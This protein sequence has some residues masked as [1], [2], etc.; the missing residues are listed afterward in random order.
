MEAKL[1]DVVT[2]RQFESEEDLKTVVSMIEK[3]LSEPYPIYT[4]RYFVHKWPHL[5][6]LAFL[7]ADPTKCI[8]CIISKLENHTKPYDQET[9]NRGY[10]AM[11]AVDPEHRRLGLGRRLVER[12]ID[13]MIGLEADEIYLETEVTNTAALRLYECK[14]TVADWCSD[15][16]LEGQAQHCLLPQR[17]RRI[18]TQALRPAAYSN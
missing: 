14:W 3:E 4:Y 16:V 18:Q 6:E 11:L 12:N 15:G 5:A 2:F 17:K 1:D 9:F 10:I 8:G 13:A 7:K